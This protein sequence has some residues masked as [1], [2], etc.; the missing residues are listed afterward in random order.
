MS[1]DKTSNECKN[2]TDRVSREP[3]T[4]RQ[5]CA[6]SALAFVTLLTLVKTEW[7]FVND[8]GAR[9]ET[10]LRACVWLYIAGLCGLAAYLAVKGYRGWRDRADRV[11][12]RL[13]GLAVLVNIVTVLAVYLVYIR[14]WVF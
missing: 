14:F 2:G 6:F 13:S 11:Q 9:I 1:D 7:P 4:W 8:T 3:P 5:S 10:A 12:T